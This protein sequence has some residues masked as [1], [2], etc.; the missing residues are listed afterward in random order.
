MPNGQVPCV[1]LTSLNFDCL[2][3]PQPKQP[4]VNLLKPGVGSWVRAS[5]NS[6]S[7]THAIICITIGGNLKNIQTELNSTSMF[8]L[9]YR[10]RFFRTIYE[11]LHGGSS[12]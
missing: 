6:L 2:A 5:R 8:R 9:G 3:Q 7:P 1:K 10:A 11:A 12:S 4:H